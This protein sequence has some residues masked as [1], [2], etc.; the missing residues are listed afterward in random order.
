MPLDVDEPV[1]GEHHVCQPFNVHRADG[2]FERL[3]STP[4]EVGQSFDLLPSALHQV[5]S[6]GCQWLV[7]VV[8]RATLWVQPATW[9]TTVHISC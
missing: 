4:K 5:L 3:L 8:L 1:G 7:S 2:A 9:K 6:F